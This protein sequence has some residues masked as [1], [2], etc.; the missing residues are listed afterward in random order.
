MADEHEK[1]AELLREAVACLD[2]AGLSRFMAQYSRADVAERLIAEMPAVSRKIFLQS[3]MTTYAAE[4]AEE[5]PQRPELR[6]VP[7]KD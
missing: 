5:P 2:A 3:I 1:H 7:R 4:L 6:L